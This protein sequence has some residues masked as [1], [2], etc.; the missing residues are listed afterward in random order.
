[1]TL[2]D[3]GAAWCVAPLLAVAVGGVLA[4]VARGV[5]WVDVLIG[6]GV[7]VV[8]TGCAIPLAVFVGRRLAARQPPPPPEEDR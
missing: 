3:R 5:P 2:S 6:L 1:M 4:T 8:W 7:L